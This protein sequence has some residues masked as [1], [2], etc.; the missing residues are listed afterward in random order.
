A[1]LANDSSVAHISIDHKL[2][3]KLD[4]TTAATNATV[5]WQSGWTGAGIGVAVIDSGISARGD[6]GK[7]AGGSRIVYS[8]DFTGGNGTD[9]YGHGTHVAGIIAGNGANSKCAGCTRT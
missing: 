2:T 4:Y 9:Q 1:D 7:S 6:F 8:Q 3:A 5:A